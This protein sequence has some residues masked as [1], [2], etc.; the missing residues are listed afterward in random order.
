MRKV[1]IEC[2]VLE[3]WC[4]RIIWGHPPPSPASECKGELYIQ[5][6]ERQR[7]GGGAISHMKGSGGNQIIGQH[8]NSG[9][10]YTI[11]YSLYDPMKRSSQRLC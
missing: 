1:N 3:F 9:A 7:E 4:C 5:G 2:S 11:L 8:R 10:L 6:V